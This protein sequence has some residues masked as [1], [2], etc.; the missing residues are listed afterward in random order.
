VC[1]CWSDT[2][3]T[4]GEALVVRAARGR[5]APDVVAGGAAR[6]GALLVGIAAGVQGGLG[7]L[8]G[9]GRLQEAA[10]PQ[11]LE[12]RHFADDVA[13]RAQ[14]PGPE[15]RGRRRLGLRTRLLLP[16]RLLL[17]LVVLVEAAH[18]PESPQGSA[19][20]VIR[21]YSSP[22]DGSSWL[23]AAKLQ[24][25]AMPIFISYGSRAIYLSDRTYVSHSRDFGFRALPLGGSRSLLPTQ[26]RLHMLN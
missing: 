20:P 26:S 21:A 5:R 4:S 9:C 6:R 22:R 14:C 16:R 23:S 13:A 15:A 17:D 10:L 25:G 12:Y 2:Y 8:W 3:R 24:A 1:V 19:G 11:M 18:R 7:A